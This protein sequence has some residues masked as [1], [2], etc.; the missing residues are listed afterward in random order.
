MK[1]FANVF[2]FVAFAIGVFICYTIKVSVINNEPS[3]MLIFIIKQFEFWS[4][5]KIIMIKIHFSY[6]V[7]TT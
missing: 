5:N 7:P 1:K 4:S 3:F 2:K 6:I